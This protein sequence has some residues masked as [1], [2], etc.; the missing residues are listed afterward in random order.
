MIIR[1]KT[2]DINN[3][4]RYFSWWFSKLEF[5]FDVLNAIVSTGAILVTVELLDNDRR[6]QLPINAFDGG[7]LLFS[8]AVQQLEREWQQLVSVSVNE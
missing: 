1:V 5:A 7:D 4:D 8:S 3:Q 6:T 2:I